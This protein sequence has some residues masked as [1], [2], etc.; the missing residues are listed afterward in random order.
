MCSWQLRRWLWPEWQKAGCRI[1]FHSW[2]LAPTMQINLFI[3]ISHYKKHLDISLF[4]KSIPKKR[5]GEMAGTMQIPMDSSLQIGQPQPGPFLFLRSVQLFLCVGCFFVRGE[6]CL[7]D[8]DNLRW[9]WRSPE[10]DLSTCFHLNIPWASHE[11]WAYHL[12]MC[13][14]APKLG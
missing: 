5:V 1:I 12:V 11:V 7:Y 13:D 10:S 2:R 3:F 6:T 4:T 8:V 14:Y 9:S